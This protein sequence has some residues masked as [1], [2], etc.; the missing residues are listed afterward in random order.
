MSTDAPPRSK[1]QARGSR[2]TSRELVL[3]AVYQWLLNGDPAQ[4]LIAQAA[5]KD[6]FARA[7]SPATI[8]K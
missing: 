7:D 6:E 3:Q 8:S 2:R 5:D 1:R 4:S